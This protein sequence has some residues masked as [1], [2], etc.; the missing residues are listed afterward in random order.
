MSL[1]RLHES[2]RSCGNSVDASEVIAYYDTF[3][4]NS[5]Q[6]Q[7]NDN[8]NT[9]G[10]VNTRSARCQRR[11]GRACQRDTNAQSDECIP[12]VVE[13]EDFLNDK[14]TKDLNDT[15]HCDSCIHGKN[16]LKKNISQR[17]VERRERTRQSRKSTNVDSTA[18]RGELCLKNKCCTSPE[19]ADSETSIS[20][21]PV[22]IGSGASG[23]KQCDIVLKCH[24]A[25][26]LISQLHA[27]LTRKLVP[28]ETNGRMEALYILENLSES[29]GTY[30]NGSLMSG[31]MRSKILVDKDLIS[32]GPPKSV[33]DVIDG[34]L[35]QNPFVYRFHSINEGQTENTVAPQ[36]CVATDTSNTRKCKRRN[37]SSNRMNDNDEGNQ[38]TEEE[39][40]PSK[41]ARVELGIVK[42]EEEKTAGVPSSMPKLA[43]ANRRG[44]DFSEELQCSI[45]QDVFVMAHALDCGHTFCGDCLFEW[46]QRKR[47]CPVCREPV[48]R[49]PI[50]I[51]SLDSIIHKS[52]EPKMGNG[53][54]LARQSR[55]ETF[56]SNKSKILD[57]FAKPIPA[58]QPSHN[59]MA[60]LAH[61]NA[62]SSQAFIIDLR[63]SPE[64]PSPVS[65]LAN[66]PPEEVD[67]R[68]MEI[69]VPISSVVRIDNRTGI[70]HVGTGQ[71]SNEGA[72]ASTNSIE[73][74]R[75]VQRQRVNTGPQQ[76]RAT[77]QR[78]E[79]EE[80]HAHMNHGETIINGAQVRTQVSVP[81]VYHQS[82][83]NGQSHHNPTREGVQRNSTESSQPMGSVTRSFPRSVGE[84]IFYVPLSL[85]AS[86]PTTN[87]SRANEE[88]YAD[89]G[90]RRLPNL[91]LS[92]LIHHVNAGMARV[93]GNEGRPVDP[94]PQRQRRAW[95]SLLRSFG[96]PTWGPSRTAETRP[97][98]ERSARLRVRNPNANSLFSGRIDNSSADNGS[99]IRIELNDHSR[100]TGG[101]ITQTTRL[102][103]WRR[104]SFRNAVGRSSGP[105]RADQAEADARY[106]GGHASQLGRNEDERQER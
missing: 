52:I 23:D 36:N 41:V 53:E 103:G 38:D 39:K 80:T 51:R 106:S 16:K 70:H 59:F 78:N 35:I 86:G 10:E 82:T 105:E 83:V 28:S 73:S 45:C 90:S 18:Q 72:N 76:Q 65:G 57:T 102:E 30:V 101:N 46:L 66:V 98:S 1:R 104:V 93:H 74:N 77:Q 24:A 12:E 63:S 19:K 64:N 32:F 49:P 4:T 87:G 31:S 8:A 85:T 71:R 14:I 9:S 27:K 99:S 13:L 20:S 54:K 68:P 37:A 97:N 47:V 25:P 34:S 96:G 91:T 60:T 5:R 42:E 50:H 62:M 15:K 7:S 69:E 26:S 88:N 95:S 40:I 55:K 92:T 21:S 67:A 6:L 3:A 61:L 79:S 22:Y 44:E 56:E 94:P 17:K 100:S 2:E 48:L 58:P 84:S 43:A 11:R 81:M 75:Q 33:I 89:D 29:S